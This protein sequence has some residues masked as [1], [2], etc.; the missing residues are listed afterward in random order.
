MSPAAERQFL[1]WVIHDIEAGVDVWRKRAMDWD[2]GD[3]RS[4]ETFI[5]DM[6]R[7]YPDLYATHVV[8]RNKAWAPLCAGLLA[9]SGTTMI[10]VGAGHC[11]GPDS[12][13]R[14]LS[15]A[16]MNPVRL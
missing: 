9:A 10:V 12:L 4:T 14:Q 3:L 11:V 8:G 6:R 16:G 5:E 13:Q 15:A 2:A 7:R 1:R